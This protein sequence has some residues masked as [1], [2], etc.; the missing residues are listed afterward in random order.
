MRSKL[1]NAVIYGIYAAFLLLSL[2]GLEAMNGA[3]P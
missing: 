2:A 1:I 3:T